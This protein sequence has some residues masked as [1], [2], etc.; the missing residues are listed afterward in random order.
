MLSSRYHLFAMASSGV[1]QMY[2]GLAPLPF[3]WAGVS[4]IFADPETHQPAC[5][6][7]LMA[8]TLYSYSNAIDFQSKT[9]EQTS[10]IV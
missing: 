5:I 8:K 3:T 2:L 4:E 7:Q 6:L 1:L 9:A 10:W